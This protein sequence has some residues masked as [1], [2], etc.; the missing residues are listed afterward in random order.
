VQRLSVGDVYLQP[1]P[2]NPSASSGQALHDIQL[3]PGC[4]LRRA[5]STS[6][7]DGE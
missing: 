7:L 1:T 6:V 2:G 4:A 3:R 5:S